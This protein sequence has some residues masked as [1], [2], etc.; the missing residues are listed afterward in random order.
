MSLHEAIGAGIIGAGTAAV[1]GVA[2]LLV[3]WVWV[4]LKYI[5]KGKRGGND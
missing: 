5:V 2:T 1:F 4:G 3:R